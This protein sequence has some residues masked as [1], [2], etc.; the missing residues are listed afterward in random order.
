MTN[1]KKQYVFYEYLKFFYRK[2]WVLLLLPIIGLVI[3]TMFSLLQERQFE[4]E[5]FV[6]IGGVNNQ[7]FS[8]DAIIEANESYQQFIPEGVKADIS[9][10]RTN[11]ISFK[12]IGDDPSTIENGLNGIA[13]AFESDLLDKYNERYSIT[14]NSIE[15]TYKIINS[16]K[17]SLPFYETALIKETLTQ[18]LENRYRELLYI[19]TNDL[20]KYNLQIRRMETD[21]AFFEEPQFLSTTTVKKEPSYLKSNLLVGALLG[22]VLSVIVLMLWKY[23]FD[24][25]KDEAAND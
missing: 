24:A 7:T 14:K 4:G 19:K 15:I 13:G 25:R 11:V 16:L 2:K 17:E 12:F 18:E 10:A 9:V 5:A 8:D 3:G 1:D 22:F 21:L 23:I 6:F 20:Y